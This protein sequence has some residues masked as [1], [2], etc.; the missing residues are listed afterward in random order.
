[1]E[2][3]VRG[4]DRR[5]D[6]R[7]VLSEAQSVLSVAWT[8]DSRPAGAANPAEGPRYARYLR[9]GDYHDEARDRMSRAAEKL[10]QAWL[11]ETGR[12]LHWK[13]CV[14]TSAVLE[15]FWA[16]AC[17]LGWIGKNA[18][19]INPKLG[20]YL[21]LGE[22]LFSEESGA[23]PQFLPD[24]CGHCTRCLEGCPTGALI[25]PRKLDAP[26]CTAYFTLEKRGAFGAPDAV[27]AKAGTWVAGCD[28]CQEVCPFNQKTAK[29]GDLREDAPINGALAI[30]DWESLLAESGEVYRAR[31]QNSALDR[32]K[33]ADFSRNLAL[34]L[35]NALPALEVPAVQALREQV[36]Q[37]LTTETADEARTQWEQTVARMN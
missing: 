32:V 21:F 16:A 8:Y 9:A 22:I 3:L 19:L 5:A 15:R 28:V 1:M 37:R 4:R 6:P 23:D 12:P 10:A 35:R 14:D 24:Y 13:S 27:T 11:A 26:T 25:A 20:S 2:Y 7:L 33:P 31:T 17:G 34:A 36:H 29:A 30:T 18:M